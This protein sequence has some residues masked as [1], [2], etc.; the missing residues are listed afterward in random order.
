MSIDEL[1]QHPFLIAVM[2]IIGLVNLIWP[3]AAWE[4]A[5]GWQFKDAEPS[6]EALL[7]ARAGGGF[8]VFLSVAMIFLW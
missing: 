5:R 2:L 6:E 1:A 7:A 4:L 3:R 8:L